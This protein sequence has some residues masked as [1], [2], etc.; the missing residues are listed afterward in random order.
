MATLGETVDHGAIVVVVLQ[1]A[2]D[3]TLGSLAAVVV[4]I[5]IVSSGGDRP[6]TDKAG[7]TTPR[8]GEPGAD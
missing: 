8:L 5:A 2:V 7:D 6:P 4:V 1:F 3:I